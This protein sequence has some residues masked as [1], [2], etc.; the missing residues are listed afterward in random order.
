[1]TYDYIS[2]RM[3]QSFEIFAHHTPTSALARSG[4]SDLVL[5]NLELVSC[6]ELAE[7]LV[8]GEGGSEG[9]E[10]EEVFG[11]AFV[12]QG[13]AAVSGE[14]GHGAFDDPA[15]PA[16]FL[17]GLD[18]FAGDADLDSAVADPAPQV[19]LVVGLVGVQLGGL[20]PAWAAPGLDRRDCHDQ[21]LEGMDVV[22]VGR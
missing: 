2:A 1:M 14:P 13:E 22:G 3:C 17:A 20:A 9:E 6:G 19:G 10:G 11:F 5:G 4:R 8:A 12:A 18:A 16:E 7:F 15:V 21:G